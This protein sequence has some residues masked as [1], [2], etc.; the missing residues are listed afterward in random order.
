MRYPVNQLVNEMFNIAD[1]HFCGVCRKASKF[2][3]FCCPSAVCKTC[4]YDIQF[5][6]VKENKGFCN[7]C[8][9]LAWLI[10]TKKDVNY[11]G[12]WMINSR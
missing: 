5:A 10:E 11:D 3:C 6:L 9:E 1:W 4:L 2:Y 8:L 7:S 12:V